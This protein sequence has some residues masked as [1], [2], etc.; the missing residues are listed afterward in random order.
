[1]FETGLEELPVE[2]LAINGERLNLSLDAKK[3]EL[4]SNV[5]R[6]SNLWGSGAGV[7]GRLTIDFF[8]Q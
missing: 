4:W 1:M 5:E 6:S 2:S 7:G 3:E 8:Q